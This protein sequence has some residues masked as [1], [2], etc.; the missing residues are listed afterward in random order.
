M[1]TPERPPPALLPWRHV[2]T[3]TAVCLALGI[4]FHLALGSAGAVIAVA[5]FALGGFATAAAGWRGCARGGAIF[6]PGLAILLAWPG[7]GALALVSAALCILAGIEVA[8]GGTQ[9]TVMALLGLVMSFVAMA[10]GSD[11]WLMAPAAVGVVAGF[12]TL[13]SLGLAGVMR[14]GPAGARHGLRMALFL[15]A[16]MTIS[17]LLV[18]NLD[19]PRSYWIAVL[20][21]SRALIPFPDRIAP[22]QRY[23]TGAA[24]GVLVAVGLEAL[25]LPVGIR[26]SIAL[27]ALVLGTR[28]MLHPRPIGPAMTTVAVLLGTAPTAT[29]ALFRA[30]AIGLVIGMI[31][32]L[33]LL[34]DRLWAWVT[35]DRPAGALAG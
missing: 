8:R 10:G 23:G 24:L 25:A 20:F 11:P 12:L 13:G 5:G 27:A 18:L 17:S 15:G 16:G 26:L 3:L 14:P 9:I 1:N 28:F 7:P 21:L 6:L 29:E 19:M 33:G 2:L 30:E 35:P 31:V 22:L 4:L 32:L 34:I